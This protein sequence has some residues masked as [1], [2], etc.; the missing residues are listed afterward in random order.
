MTNEE[1]QIIVEE[2]GKM[3]E[4][5]K[6]EMDKLRASG[7]LQQDIMAAIQDRIEFPA[8][9]KGLATRTVASKTQAVDEAGASQ[10]D[11]AKIMSGFITV[12]FNGTD[13]DLAYYT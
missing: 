5:M 13:Y 11:V 6:I 2:Q 8:V 1:L 9:I 3:I 7:T 10:Y 4:E 12:T